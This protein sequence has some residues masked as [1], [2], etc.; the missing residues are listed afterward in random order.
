MHRGGEK[1][2]APFSGAECFSMTSNALLARLLEHI[3][4][5]CSKI[6]CLMLFHL[7]LDLNWCNSV[8]ASG[9]R[10]EVGGCGGDA[11]ARRGRANGSR[12]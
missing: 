7:G 6:N 8:L 2:G 1:T 10:G 5:L 12:G 4:C 9:A 11:R 3:T